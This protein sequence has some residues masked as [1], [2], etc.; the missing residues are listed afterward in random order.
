MTNTPDLDTY[1][2]QLSEAQ[3]AYKSMLTTVAKRLEDDTATIFSGIFEKYP[4]LVQ[5]S[6]NQY[7]PYFNDGEP[8][9]FTAR[10]D[11]LSI[12]D[13][14]ERGTGDTMWVQVDR[15]YH[16]VDIHTRAMHRYDGGVKKHM[17]KYEGDIP[18]ETYAAN[19]IGKILRVF[20][21]EILQ[22]AFGNHVKVT[23][24]RDL[25]VTTDQYDH[26]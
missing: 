26:E 1:L 18:W 2:K 25:G 8:C 12:N 5:F 6:W 22:R 16:Y 24:H 20:D 23:I 14:D 10:I 21:E 7:T 13:E 19:S 3:E 4:E 15:E 17:G 9:E 11:D